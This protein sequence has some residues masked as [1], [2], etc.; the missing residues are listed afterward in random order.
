MRLWLVVLVAYAS[1]FTAFVG[2]A[3][4]ETRVALIIGNSAYRS[5]GALPNPASDAAAMGEL[6][7][8]AG[9]DDVRTVANLGVNDMR[10][11]LRDFAMKATWADIAVLFYAGHGIEIGGHNY[12]IPV[13]AALAHDIDVEDETVDLDRILQLLE[14]ARRARR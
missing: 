14:P 1:V 3:Q 7:R 10:K 12:L 13:D 8:A 5:V 6:F 11:E 4:A 2:R 9:F